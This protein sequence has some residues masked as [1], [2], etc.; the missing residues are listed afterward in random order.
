MDN[1]RPSGNP[2]YDRTKASDQE[3]GVE[4]DERKQ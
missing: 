1:L 2:R 3:V 4:H